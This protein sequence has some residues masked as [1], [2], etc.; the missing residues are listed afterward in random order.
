MKATGYT[1]TK[2]L[3]FHRMTREIG[4][5][6]DFNNCLRPHYDEP[7]D[8]AIR[9]VSEGSKLQPHH[10]RSLERYTSES[11]LEKVLALDKEVVLQHK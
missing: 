1:L 10:I 6:N 9:F 3:L 5:S 4:F 11:T 2:S 7:F 8:D